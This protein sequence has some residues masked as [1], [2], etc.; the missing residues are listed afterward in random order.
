MAKS[1][2]IRVKLPALIVRDKSA[3]RQ[4]IHKAVRAA[5][6]NY[7]PKTQLEIDVLF[8][9][10][11]GKGVI[12]RDV[13]NLVKH[14]LDALQARYGSTRGVDAFIANDNCVQRVVVEKQPRPKNLDHT[15]GGKLLIRPYVRH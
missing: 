12:T 8:Y 4:A 2:V 7:A 6:V 10:S 15:Y 3:W 9:L 13:D 11:K 5:K 1:R 14:V